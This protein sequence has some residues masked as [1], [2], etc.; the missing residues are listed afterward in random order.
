MG[1]RTHNLN[2]VLRH[3]SS[4][5]KSR[6]TILDLQKKGVVESS[7]IAQAKERYG[8]PKS[9]YLGIKWSYEIIPPY[10]D[11]CNSESQCLRG[12]FGAEPNQPY[13]RTSIHLISSSSN[14]DLVNG[15]N[16]I[17]HDTK[18]FIL[19]ETVQIS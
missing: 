19:Y 10:V 6:R 8:I 13:F 16:I 17:V 9:Q 11:N 4:R 15:R 12:Y 18:V 3:L 7:E 1:S 2:Y 14:R 5:F